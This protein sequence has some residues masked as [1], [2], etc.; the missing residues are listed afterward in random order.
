[1]LNDEEC[2]Q[3]AG[4][5]PATEKACNVGKVCPKWHTGAWRPVNKFTIRNRVFLVISLRRFHLIVNQ[6]C[7]F[8]SLSF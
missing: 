1:M 8:S 4:N 6:I 7:V 3:R 2:L 5:K